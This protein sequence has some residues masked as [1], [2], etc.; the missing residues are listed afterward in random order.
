MRPC[1]LQ[2]RRSTFFAGFRGGGFLAWLHIGRMRDR[3]RP[4]NRASAASSVKTA[5]L[6]AWPAV[7]AS[8]AQRC[9]K[10]R[11]GRVGSSIRS[12][13]V[14]SALLEH[15][16]ERGHGRAANANQMDMLALHTYFS[17]AA[18][19]ALAA[20]LAVAASR[21]LIRTL[22]LTSRET[23]MPIGSVMFSPNT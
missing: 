7:P 19:C 3:N 1:S 23:L 15:S 8:D 18:E 6:T 14:S 17:G 2:F 21:I 4:A 22:S 5:V 10:I 13:D 16:G 12:R 11:H 20:A 9:Q